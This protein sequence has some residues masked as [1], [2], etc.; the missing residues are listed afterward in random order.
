MEANTSFEKVEFANYAHAYDRPYLYLSD[1]LAFAQP[2]QIHSLTKAH[3]CHMMEIKIELHG[4]LICFN[5][6]NPSCY[7]M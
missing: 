4:I 6:I 3:Y 1:W 5:C 7:N 2:A